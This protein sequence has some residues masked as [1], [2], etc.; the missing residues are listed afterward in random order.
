M[1]STPQDAIRA[2]KA[3]PWGS[4]DREIRETKK[5]VEKTLP[6]DF[7]L[8]RDL[9]HQHFQGRRFFFMVVS[10]TSRVTG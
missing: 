3:L 6:L 9:F 5:S 1:D 4:K 2:Y 7:V 10:L 8:G